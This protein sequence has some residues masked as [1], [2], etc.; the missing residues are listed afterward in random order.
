M[1]HKTSYFETIDRFLEAVLLDQDDNVS[2][3]L[4]E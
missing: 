1:G 2:T 3:D 4:L